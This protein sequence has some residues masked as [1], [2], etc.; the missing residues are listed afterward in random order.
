MIRE[1]I[2]DNL[3]AKIDKSVVRS[4]LT[5]YQKMVAE[6]QKGA[7]EACLVQAGKFVEHTLRAL[8]QVRTGILPSEI[9]FPAETVK[10]IEKDKA[11]PESLRILMPRIAYS[12]IYEVR[13]KRG[14]VHVKEVDPRD[15]DAALAVQAASW[16]IAEFLRLY[17]TADEGPVAEAMA[18][19]MRA[20]MPL[21]EVLGNEAVVTTNVPCPIELLLL[22]G[23]AADGID[24]RS[25]GLSS[26]NSPTTISKAL[27]RLAGDRLVHKA[28]DGRFHITGPGE[29][30][31][32]E[33]VMKLRR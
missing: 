18:A 15:I 4:L 10:L 12:M 26:K 29:R 16:I 1:L 19:L 14:A 8:E 30:H 21:V 17:H 31:L 28:T 6:R 5:S 23:R 25:L 13:S 27:Q 11:L 32:N 7:S 20:E 22:I 2:E 24:R 33:A 3:S 9:K